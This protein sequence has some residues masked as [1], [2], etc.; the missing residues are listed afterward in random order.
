MSAKMANVRNTFKET[1]KLN[2]KYL[3]CSCV[4]YGKGFQARQGNVRD[5][6]CD[7]V[8]KNIGNY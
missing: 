8:W 7:A 4:S 6:T 3:K 1:L 5:Y 2:E